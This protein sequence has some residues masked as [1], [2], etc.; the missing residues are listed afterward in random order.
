MLLKQAWWLA[1]KELQPTTY[2]IVLNMLF[3]L[4]AAGV[5]LSMSVQLGDTDTSGGM[6]PF[7]GIVLNFFVMAILPNLGFL[8]SRRYMTY[9]TTDVFTK[10]L[11]FM[12]QLP[13]PLAVIVSSRFMQ[14]LVTLVPMALVL[15]AGYGI[16]AAAL[17]LVSFGT[18]QFVGFFVFWI[19]YSIVFGSLNLYWELGLTGRQYFNRCM[20]MVPVYIT[21]A[22]ILW[23]W[24]GESV[25]TRSLSWVDDT[26]GLISL[27]SLA[28]AALVV[29][30][31][32]R[33]LVGR[34]RKRDWHG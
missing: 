19:G 5:I 1:R 12:R 4:Y 18:L 17:K 26:H 34:L 10:K 11:A 13:I 2:S 15:F 27:L 24:L 3:Y 29:L 23:L 28:I 33:A 32:G 9:R 14:L 8:I 6:R 7:T 30:G 20:M 21:A 25:W 31:I 16:V 22:V